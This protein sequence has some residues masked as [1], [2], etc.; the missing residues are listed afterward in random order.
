MGAGRELP[1]AARARTTRRG[2]GP[3]VVVLGGGFAGL[4][5]LRS[6]PPRFRI[7]LVDERDAFEFLPNV[8][9]LL[10]G[11]KTPELLRLPLAP[12][13]RRARARFVRA[14]VEEVEPKERR[15]RL[16]SGRSLSYD[17]LVFALGGTSSTRGVEGAARFAF[18]LKSVEE[19]ARIAE[20]LDELAAE[21]G[22]PQ[23][24]VVVGGG[25]EGVEALGEIL[26]RD[27]AGRAFRATLVEAGPRL[28]PE[29]PG[30]VARS[31]ARHAEGRGAVLRTGVPV[32]AVGA[33]QVV[34]ASGERL[35]SRCTIWTGGP[36]PSPVLATSGL[37]APGEACHVQDTLAHP[38]HPEL[39]VCGDAAE[40][41]KPLAKQGYFALDMGTR[42]ARN[43]VR[44]LS[45]AEPEPFRAQEKPA[46][47]TFGDLDTYLVWGRLALASPLLAGTKEAIYELLMARLD[48]RP[49]VP[50]ARDAVRRLL[51]A[52]RG[53]VWPGLVSP[54]ALLRAGR[55]E[56]LGSR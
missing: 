33:R 40:L 52:G 36:A 35:P 21:G 46:L 2:Q 26:R 34:L 24:V 41:P 51:E 27:P 29:A 6:L 4:A 20:R 43:A 25:L 42:A 14:R 5:A 23:P 13:V 28:L 32:S 37:A 9:Q 7:T 53:L 30:G 19:V 44:R 18:S 54:A 31:I 45:G 16:A 15:V 12:L 10:S 1:M 47:V 49:P 22:E 39:F 11:L 48:D 38:R 8:H 56:V 50:R 55:F 17:A 3:E